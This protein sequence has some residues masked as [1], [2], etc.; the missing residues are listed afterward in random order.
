[1]NGTKPKGPS[2]S[3]QVSGCGQCYPRGKEDVHAAMHREVR[4]TR[5]SIGI[6]DVSTLGKIDIQG[7]DAAKFLNRAY[8]NGLDPGRRQSPLWPDAP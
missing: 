8:S 6:C 5:K 4:M 7:P 1:M 3:R 2:L